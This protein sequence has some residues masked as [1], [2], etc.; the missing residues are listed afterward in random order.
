[1]PL[2]DRGGVLLVDCGANVVCTPEYLLQFAY[3]GSY[4]MQ[5]VRNRNS[6]ELPRVGLLNIGA[7]SHKGNELQQEAYKLLTAAHEAGSLN[8]IGNVEGRDIPFGVADVVVADGFAG[9]ICLKTLEG[10][11]KLFGQELKSIIYG[12]LKS[13][14]GGLILKKDLNGLKKK[15]DYKEIGGSPLIGI[16]APVFKAHGSADAFTLKNA[17]KQS[18]AYVEGDI[19]RHITE[20]IDRMKTGR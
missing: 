12:S 11:G 3:M 9:N 17:I 16:S 2:G 18:I 8:F 15:L 19:I 1:M 5:F 14:I 7:E 6:D 10:M 13:K 4:Y 20:N